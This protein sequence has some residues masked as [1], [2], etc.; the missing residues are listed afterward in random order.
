MQESLTKKQQAVYDYL[1]GEVRRNGYPPSIK[2]ICDALGLRSTVTVH[3]HLTVLEKK[4][5]IRKYPTKNRT[6]ELVDRPP[7][8]AP[9]P[10]RPPDTPGRFV[11]RVQ[12]D[13]L[14]HLGLLPGDIV[15]CKR[16]ADKGRLVV[17]WEH[18]GMTLRPH[19]QVDFK[20]DE[21]LGIAVEMR[22]KFDT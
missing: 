1:L 12:H 3:S 18:G 2:D 22:R 5:Y 14:R 9:A 17:L 10:Q 7:P 21:V 4:G 6:F 13:N 16:G 8:A 19:D 20:N 15:T 11:Y